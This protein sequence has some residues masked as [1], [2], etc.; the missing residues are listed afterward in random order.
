MARRPRPGAEPALDP[1][2]RV[3]GQI[4]Q[5]DVLAHSAAVRHVE[6]HRALSDA[7]TLSRSSHERAISKRLDD[8]RQGFAMDTRPCVSEPPAGP[9]KSVSKVAFSRGGQS[10]APAVAASHGPAVTPDNKS[11]SARSERASRCS[12]SASAASNVWNGPPQCRRCRPLPPGAHC[13]E[14]R[15][16]VSRPCVQKDHLPWTA[17]QPVPPFHGV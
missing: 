13:R 1:E 6:R 12:S 14:R 11:A 7:A 3:G 2:V 15:R 8:A 16:E 17:P 9:A 10:N 5:H 4:A